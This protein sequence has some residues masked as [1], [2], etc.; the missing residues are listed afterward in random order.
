MPKGLFKNRE[1]L[2]SS[3][4]GVG[5]NFPPEGA[6]ERERERERDGPSL[7]HL[8]ARRENVSEPQGWTFLQGEEGGSGKKGGE[9]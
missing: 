5:I 8:A 6:R 9:L 3:L 2:F 7:G 1:G 4:I